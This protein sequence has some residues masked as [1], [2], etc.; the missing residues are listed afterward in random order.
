MHGIAPDMIDDDV[1]EGGH[2]QFARALFLACTSTVWETLQGGWRVADFA[3]QAPNQV[4]I[5][6]NLFHFRRRFPIC[7]AYHP[8]PRFKARLRVCVF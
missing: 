6:V 2:H 8:V 1:R 7:L 3:Y 5:A 4:S